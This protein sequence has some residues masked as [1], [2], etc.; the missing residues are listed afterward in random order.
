[1]MAAMLQIGTSKKVACLTENMRASYLNPALETF[2]DHA[3][4]IRRPDAEG[5]KQ[6]M[7]LTLPLAKARK[8]LETARAKAESDA[9]AARIAEQTARA[10][11]AKLKQVRKLAKVTRKSARKAEDQATVTREAFERAREKLEKVERRIKKQQRKL[12]SERKAAASR[13]RPRPHLK[14]TSS[15]RSPRLQTVRPQFPNV[16]PGTA[17]KESVDESAGLSQQSVIP[18]TT[19][20]G[21]DS[22]PVER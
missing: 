19:P 5:E 1:M 18:E 17:A 6:I 2:G 20:S 8:A 21:T 13:K 15:K 10:A 14:R 9:K 7:N 16:L 12:D 22:E 3:R 11:K 4:T